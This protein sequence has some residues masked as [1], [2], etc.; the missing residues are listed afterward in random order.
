MTAAELLEELGP[1]TDISLLV[2]NFN[3][4]D[5]VKIVETSKGPAIMFASQG[6]KSHEQQRTRTTPR[7]PAN[8]SA[9]HATTS[10][11]IS[12]VPAVID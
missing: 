8:G 4:T 11:S 6:A 12:H 1:N 5:K 9:C 3:Q 10:N 7:R 2:L